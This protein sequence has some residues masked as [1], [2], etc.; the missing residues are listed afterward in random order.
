MTAAGGTVETRMTPDGV[1]VLQLD[2]PPANAL[3]PGLRGALLQALAEASAPQVRAVV[4]TAGGRNFSSAT[5]IDMAEGSPSL[6]QLCD[7][8]EGLPVPFVVALQGLAVGPGAELALAAHARVMAETARIVLPD[9]GLG[10]VPEAGATQRLPRLVGVAEALGILLKARAVPADEALALGL[11]D[12]IVEGDATAAAIALAGRMTGPRPVRDRMDGIGNFASNMAAIAA[13]RAEAARGVLPAPARLIDCVEAALVLPYDNGMAMEAVAREDLAETAE[14]RGLRAAA[15]AERRAAQL[16]PVMA[17]VR[18]KTVSVLGLHGGA[19][20]MA[21]LALVALSQGLQVVW[22]DGDDTRRTASLRWIS[23][24]QEA[25][26]RAGRLGSVQRDADRARLMAGADPGLLLGADLVILSPLQPGPSSVPVLGV[27]TSVPR[28]YLGGGEGRIGLALAPSARAAE[29]AMPEGPE[30]AATAAQLAV[31]VQFLRRIGVAPVLT[32][33]M[34]ILG[35][36]VTAAGRAALSRLL[37]LGV[38]RRVLV[39][40]LDGFGQAL[41]ELPEPADPAPMRAIPEEEV[42]NRWLGAMANTGLGL[43]D[44]R[45]ARRPSD[46][47][48]VLVAGHGFPRWRGG[49]MHHAATRGLMV[50]RQDLRAWEKDDAEL[51][52]PHPIL[53]RMIADGRRLAELDG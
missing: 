6:A 44:A 52:R 7:V 43:L 31:A 28:V 13:A 11:A 38:P 33:K 49:P 36:R 27:P 46:I 26:V 34:P 29:L 50:L 30:V 35:R 25:E 16:P 37:A 41:P 24:R 40:A 20:Q 1:L 32:G 47:D 48:L 9:I 19:P 15:L 4:L 23:D 18:P 53:D 51:W 5:T 22:V 3:T 14:A 21:A 12:Q 10:L 45:V 8:I 39:A 2:H 42:I 17:K